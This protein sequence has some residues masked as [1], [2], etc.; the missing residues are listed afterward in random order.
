MCP[1]GGIG[2]LGPYV[3]MPFAKQAAD[4]VGV[5][6]QVVKRKDYKVNEK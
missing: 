2:L 6:P 5:E 4:K 3:N 1:T